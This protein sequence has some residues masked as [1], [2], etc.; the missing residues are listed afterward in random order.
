M[1]SPNVVK[2]SPSFV[3]NTIGARG[4]Y[5]G[6]SDSIGYGPTSTT[7]FWNGYTPGASGY[8]VYI[9]KPQNGPS[10][11]APDSDSILID[12]AKVIAQSR[13]DSVTLTTA[14]QCLAY[15]NSKDDMICVNMNYPNIITDGLVLMLDAA[16]TA[17]YPKGGTGWIDLSSSQKIATLI[18]GVTYSSN[19][20]GSL[21]Y[22]SASLQFVDVPELGSLTQF[23]VSCWFKLDSLPG[24]TGAAAVVTNVF[25]GANLNFSIGLNNSPSSANICAGFFN[26]AWRTTSGFAPSVNTWYNVTLTYDGSTVIQYVDGSSQSTLSYTGTPASGGLGNRIGRRWDSVPS[27]VDFI[28]GQIPLVYIYNRA[29]TASE[30]LTNY[31]ST[32]SRFDGIV[33]TGLILQL[34]AN[35]SASYP[36]TGTSVFNLQGASY[37]HTLTNAPY[38]VLDGIKCFDCN[39][40]ST[41]IISVPQGTGPTLPTTG[42]TYI[43]WARVRS[44]SASWRTLFRTYPD[45]H[46]ILVQISTDNLG[47]YDNGINSFIDSGFD[48]TPIED[49]WV[50]YSVVGD[51]SS[52][53]F[54][55]ND[56]QVGSTG[57]GA[58]GNTHWAWGSING[59]PFGY[60]AN[61]Y[62]YNRKLTL[63][64]ITNQ[65]T[66]L[67]QRFPVS[68]IVNNLELYYDPSNSN[69]YS[70][71][72]TTLNDLSGNTLTGT[73]SNISFTSPYFT[74][75]GSSSTTSTPDNSLLEPGS[76]DWTIEVWINHAV[77]TGASRCIMSKTDGGNANQWGYG[78]RTSSTGVTY[79][80]VGNGTTSV[81]SP[82]FTLS[83]NT[84]YQVV[85]VWTNV[86]TN[87]IALY[88]N[89][90][91]Q[92][93]NSHSF[94]SIRNTTR[95]LS[96]GSFDGGATFGQWVN[97][98]MGIV[99]MYSS[100]LSSEEVLQNFNADKSKYGL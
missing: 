78:L 4:I 18:N 55:I 29:L 73:L 69:S 45:D 36:G 72:G 33:T 2:M 10:I 42:Y 54:Y 99:R 97:G 56:V 15:L 96:L 95:P 14:A 71:S 94:T 60:V 26:G 98:K 19:N 50:Q 62:L 58:G 47:F 86:S 9:S 51:S 89:G 87:S 20:Q 8:V 68:P 63:D 77:I 40:T 32:A 35:N 52:S 7:D 44:S 46:P 100:A 81:T 41:T 24:T 3:T 1:P 90:V 49:V 70:G 66:Y 38:T 79:M 25:D 21:D 22:N 23:T 74:Y 82:T 57:A 13:G 43:T 34:D 80:E 91:S 5:L 39:G 64:E 30:V 92:G 65:Y 48:V 11:Y 75:N 88:I 12:T 28:D 31:N 83:T 53:I 6:L 67:S 17:S 27:Q 59:Q 93:S 16:F 61:M 84:W 37:T 76:G 85:G